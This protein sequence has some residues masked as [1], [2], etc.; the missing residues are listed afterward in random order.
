MDQENTRAVVAGGGG[1]I[2]RALCRAFLAR[3]WK[4]VSLTRGDSRPAS[5]TPEGALPESVHWDGRSDGEWN[6]LVDGAAVVVNLAGENIS[7]GR[8]TPDRKR[9]ILESRVFAGQALCR[10]VDHA[11]KKPGVFIQSSA[12]G[13]YGD[14]GDDPVDESSPPGAGF[15]ADV[16]LQWEQSSRPVETMGVRRAVVRTGIVLGRGGGVLRKMLTPFKLFMGGAFG[17]GRQGFPWIHLA[18]EVGAI[19]YLID[20][21]EASGPFN[22]TAPESASNRGFCEELGKALSRPCGLPVPAAALRLVFGEMASELLLAGNRPFPRRLMELGYV[23]E[24]PKLAGA[25]KNLTSAGGPNRF[26]TTDG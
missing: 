24:H 17:S 21:P 18:D 22:L 3:G 12:V 5:A 4:V 2:G 23:F 16:S 19:L 25:L 20:T 26:E 6:R 10:A 9:A 1:F 15:L 8:W 13:Y 7:E 14:S 11:G